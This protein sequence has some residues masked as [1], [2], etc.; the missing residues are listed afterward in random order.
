MNVV[1]S[2]RRASLTFFFDLYVLVLHKHHSAIHLIQET[3]I[4]PHLITHHEH[5]ANAFL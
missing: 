1:V 3:N 2:Q 4:R 5:G